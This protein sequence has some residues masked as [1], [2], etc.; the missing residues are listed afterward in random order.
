MDATQIALLRRDLKLSQAE[1][2]QL[3]GAH[4][5]TISKWER[6]ALSPSAY[7]VALLSQFRRTVDAQK[8]SDEEK[9]KNLLVGAGVIAALVWL[10][11]SAK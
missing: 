2:A 3:F 4:A 5:M 9:A 8:K 11:G 1:F 10:L 6:G 7:Q